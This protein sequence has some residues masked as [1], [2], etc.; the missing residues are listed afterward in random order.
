MNLLEQQTQYIIFSAGREEFGVTIDSVREII[1]TSI[2][3]P[4]PKSPDFIKGIINVRG[5]IVTVINIK[6]L[7]C[8]AED[9]VSES[10]H[11]IVIKPSDCLFGFIVDEVI[12]VLRVDNDKIKKC[13]ELNQEN[14]KYV[15]GILSYKG[16]LIVLLNLEKASSKVELGK[17]NLSNKERTLSD[18]I[19][20]KMEAYTA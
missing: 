18:Q 16:R 10:K 6:S 17:L 3:T 5:E 13:Y 15:S 7:F 1:K 20:K 12:E 19:G 11:I 2:I 9:E 14:E 8:L 4:I